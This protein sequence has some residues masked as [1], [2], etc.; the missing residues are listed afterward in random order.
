MAESSQ[1]ER[2]PSRSKTRQ[3]IRMSS[4]TQPS[5]RSSPPVTP[6]S[7]MNEAISMWSGETGCSQP[8]SAPM[9]WTYMTLEP[10]PSIA[11]PILLS[12]RAR[13]WTCG[14]LAALRI[15]VVPG[16]S[17]AAISAFSV[18]ITDGSSMKKSVERSPPLGAR[19]LMWRSCSTSA[20][21]A[22]KASRCGSSRRRPMTSPPGGGI[23]AEPKR[24]SSGPATRKE[25]RMRSAS[26]G[27]T[28]VVGMSAAVSAT[29]LS[30][31]RSTATPRSA[32]SVSMA[33][34]S[35]MRGTLA[36]S[37]RSSVRRLAASSGSAAF[38]FPAAWMVPES[39]TPP[40]MTSFSM[41]ERRA[42]VTPMSQ[43]LSRQEAWSLFCEWTESA[44][45]RKH[46]LA[47]EAAMRAYAPRFHGDEE[48]WGLVG[49][50]HDLDYERHPDMST[51]H[52]RYGMAELE[53]QGFSPEFVRAV[54]SHA[55]YLDVPRETPMEKALYAVDELSGFIMAC[56][57]VRPQGI[58]GMTAKSVKK[59][60]K[61]PAFAAAIDRDALRAGAEDLGVDFDEH[62]A[63][64]IA[65]LAARSGELELDGAE[66]QPAA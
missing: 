26:A 1:R 30:S 36:I 56:A 5:I 16:V 2:R 41:V 8:P 33:S 61:T 18:P 10:M 50:L 17:A 11:A 40:S 66:P 35:R 3:I 22:R 43:P 39:G 45:L 65:A 58:H 49:M 46:V 42:R 38:L 20:P 14:S 27:S 62:V 7:A 29:L 6:A 64:V 37:T 23:R 54:A 51:G 55:D 32:S 25:A 44:S 59:K 52:P 12:M 53:K 15:T 57:Y 19:S 13:S 34:V 9:P 48:E 4:G 21:S 31:S 47:V 60:M 28:S 24:A 63:T